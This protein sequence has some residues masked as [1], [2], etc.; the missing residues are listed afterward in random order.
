[1]VNVTYI[2]HPKY[3]DE[4]KYG[5]KKLLKSKFSTINLK[6]LWD[7]RK[8]NIYS[9]EYLKWINENLYDNKDRYF[10]DENE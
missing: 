9:D 10:I 2:C 5:Y 6:Y 3:F 7:Y 8:N 1:M 4:I